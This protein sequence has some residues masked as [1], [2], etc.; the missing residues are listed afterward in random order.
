MEEKLEG[1][2]WFLLAYD[3]CEE[4]RLDAVSPLAEDH[5]PRCGVGFHRPTPDYVRF[6]HPPVVEQI[7]PLIL[8]NGD[9]LRGE[10]SFYD[11]GVISVKL[12]LPFQ[13]TWAELVSRS[14]HLL[15][16]PKPKDYAAHIVRVHLDRIRAAVVNPREQWLAEE[17]H[18]VHVSSPAHTARALMERNGTD[19]ARIVRGEERELSEAENEEILRS[20]MSYYPIDLMVVGWA[21]A[22]IYDTAEGAAGDL[23]LLEYANSQLLEF[24]YYDQVLTRVLED[25]YKSLEKRGL[26]SGWRM[27]REARRLNTILLDVRELTERTDTSIKFLS[28]MFSARLYR[29]AAERLGVDDYRRLVDGKVKTASELYGFMMDQ[30]HQSRA[31]VLELMVVIILIIDL[32]FLFRGER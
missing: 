24:R 1:T 10:L 8:E 14:S 29:L 4:I 20:R 23:Q 25:V 9:R 19:I 30:F 28:D 16:A 2:F 18:T 31:F 22:F 17:Y 32:I 7:G 11:Y 26:F 13:L 12:E 21:A 6:E 3:V 15:D 27:A 5:S